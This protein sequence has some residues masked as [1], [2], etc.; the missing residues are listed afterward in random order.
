M[1]SKNWTRLTLAAAIIALSALIAVPASA[2]Q[3]PAGS[4]GALYFSHD[5]VA[6]GFAKGGYLYPWGNGNFSVMTARRD[7]AGEVELHTRDTDV[8]YIV[9]G[10]ATFVTGGT[11]MDGHQT[12]PGEMRGSSI[13]GGK[14]WFLSKG[15]VLVIPPNTPHWFQKVPGPMLYFVVKVRQ[16]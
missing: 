2:A 9:S 15:D 7:K 14:A 3:T 12:A 6:K 16:K 11:M 13:Q 8:I 1:N 10:R 5:Q 4:H